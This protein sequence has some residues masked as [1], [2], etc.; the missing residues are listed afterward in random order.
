MSAR[1]NRGSAGKPETVRLRPDRGGGQTIPF[2]SSA[3]AVVIHLRV[4]CRMVDGERPC[5]LYWASPGMRRTAEP[6]GQKQ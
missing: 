4:K 1:C 5:S 6:G 3:G 2:G